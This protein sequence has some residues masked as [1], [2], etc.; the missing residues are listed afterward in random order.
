M[1]GIKFNGVCILAETSNY[2][3]DKGNSFPKVT[4]GMGTG[5]ERCGISGSL[6]AKAESLLGQMVQVSGHVDYKTTFEGKAY[7]QFVVDDLQPVKDK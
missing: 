7:H 1:I 5:A 6:L 4:L 3:N 2:T